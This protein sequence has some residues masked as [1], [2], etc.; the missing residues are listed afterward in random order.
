MSR[1]FVERF[2]FNGL[3]QLSSK[4]PCSSCQIAAVKPAMFRTVKMI[5]KGSFGRVYL[6]QENLS[7]EILVKVFFM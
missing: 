2:Q 6:V 7:G 1:E 4:S 3:Y 5:G